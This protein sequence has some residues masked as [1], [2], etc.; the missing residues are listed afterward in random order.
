MNK[1]L[2]VF[3]ITLVLTVSCVQQDETQTISS[4]VHKQE[5]IELLDDVNSTMRKAIKGEVSQQA[6][7]DEINP[8]MDKFFKLMKK[9]LPA[10]TLDVHNYRVQEVNKII[11]LQV[12]QNRR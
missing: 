2:F 6:T 1:L 4:K 8:K 5:A 12:E 9:M 7:N 11:D 10:D 3:L